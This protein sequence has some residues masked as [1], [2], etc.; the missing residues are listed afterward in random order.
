M[1]INKLLTCSLLLLALVGCNNKTSSLESA[2]PSVSTVVDNRTP[3]EKVLDVCDIIIDD[4]DKQTIFSSTQ[5]F[6][7]DI[8]LSSLDSSTSLYKEDK[9]SLTNLTFENVSEKGNEANSDKTYNEIK[10]TYKVVH[11][12][13]YT[14][15][16]ENPDELDNFTSEETLDEKFMTIGDNLYCDL[17]SYFEE[18]FTKEAISA[19]S[20]L[21]FV[22][23]DISSIIEE[24]LNEVTPEGDNENSN[25]EIPSFTPQEL[26]NEFVGD[27]SVFKNY[28]KYSDKD[29]L[30]LTLELKPQDFN[31]LIN[32]LMLEFDPESTIPIS[33]IISM[34]TG[35]IV[36]NFNFSSNSIESMNYIINGQFDL[37]SSTYIL[38][39]NT[40]GEAIINDVSEFKYLEGY[41]SFIK[42]EDAGINFKQILSDILS[43]IEFNNSNE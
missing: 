32:N 22:Q 17:S 5:V 4:F 11:R 8:T 36:L 7:G 23:N 38:N 42:F 40:S 37:L 6:N 33:T 43:N 28:L 16:V 15:E 9:I 31:E 13:E 41:Q 39:A 25:I 18:F 29:G 2:S 3:K 20:N 34:K 14:L 21:T 10:G 26:L 19:S 12:E 1:R 24:L 27:D 30:K 35:K